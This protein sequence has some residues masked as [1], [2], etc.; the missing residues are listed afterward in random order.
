MD[1]SVFLHSP[2]S[3]TTIQKG[4]NKS[5]LLQFILSEIFRCKTAQNKNEDIANIFFPI[6]SSFYPLDWASQRGYLN[7]VV[8]HSQLL[9]KAFAENLESVAIFRHS[10]TNTVT[11]ISNHLEETIPHFDMQLSLYLKQLYL[12]LE[13]LMLQCKEDENFIFFLLKNQQ[14]IHSLTHRTYLLSFLEKHALLDIDHL[15]ETLCD[16]FHSRG[17]AFLIPEVKSAIL[18]LK[19]KNE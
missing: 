14:S 1:N 4:N 8:E 3:E 6:S 7:K 2:F 10:L 13:P 16:R 15:C 12:T 19:E 11:A 5:L 9:K 18:Y 17:F